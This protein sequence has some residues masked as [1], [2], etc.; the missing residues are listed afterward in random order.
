MFDVCVYIW[1]FSEL[2]LLIAS[3]ADV[4]ISGLISLIIPIRISIRIQIS[5]SIIDPTLTVIFRVIVLQEHILV[6][7]LLY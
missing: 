5:I 2:I 3:V 1:S 7:H 4:L 6:I